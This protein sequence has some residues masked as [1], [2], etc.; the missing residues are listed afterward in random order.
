MILKTSDCGA[1]GSE[2]RPHLPG[3]SILL[4][5]TRGLAGALNSAPL[6][7]ALPLLRLWDLGKFADLLTLHNGV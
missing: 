1:E 4:W 3:K 7:P 5:K 6:T 2:A